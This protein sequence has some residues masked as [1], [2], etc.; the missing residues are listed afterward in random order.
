MTWWIIKDKYWTI[1][2][3]WVTITSGRFEGVF[4]NFHYLILFS[5]YRMIYV[6][7]K[8]KTSWKKRQEKKTVMKINLC[9]IPD[10][11][12]LSPRAKSCLSALLYV[13]TLQY[14]ITVN[15]HIK[16]GKT[17]KL[18]VYHTEIWEQLF[19]VVSSKNKPEVHIEKY[20][21]IKHVSVWK[22]WVFLVISC[23]FLHHKYVHVTY[24]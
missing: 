4:I 19:S 24:M 2:S 14:N 5:R 21:R 13:W 9:H 8:Y 17:L 23:I 11:I 3:P 20:P 10:C 7:I 18:S 1:W 12:W 15:T 22:L 6:G 16:I